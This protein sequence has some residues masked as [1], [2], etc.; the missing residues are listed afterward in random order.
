MSNSNI[1]MWQGSSMLAFE[2][3]GWHYISGVVL[4]NL[5][6]EVILTSWE[7]MEYLKVGDIIEISKFNLIKARVKKF[8]M[9]WTKIGMKWENEKKREQKNVI[10]NFN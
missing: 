6:I 5:F 1:P 9:S 10:E 7:A 2:K 3:C 8:Q 4:W